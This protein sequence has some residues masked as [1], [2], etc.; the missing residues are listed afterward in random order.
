ME[1]PWSADGFPGD[2]GVAGGREARGGGARLHRRG[3]GVIPREDPQEDTAE[4]PGGQEQRP[5]QRG[6]DRGQT[7]RC[8]PQE[9]GS[10]LEEVGASGPLLAILITFLRRILASC[11]QFEVFIFSPRWEVFVS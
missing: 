5:L 2:G 11:R 6:G 8:R 1:R 10:L 9:T 7:Q 3:G 4:A